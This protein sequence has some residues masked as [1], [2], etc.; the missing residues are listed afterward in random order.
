MTTDI[1]RCRCGAPRT[2]A[3]APGCRLAHGA[4][5]TDCARDRARREVL[6]RAIEDAQRP[7]APAPAPSSLA[8]DLRWRSPS[9]TRRPSLDR[10]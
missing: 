6:M 8:P 3:P 9:D 2:D 1:P 10:S 7:P 5:A 4:L